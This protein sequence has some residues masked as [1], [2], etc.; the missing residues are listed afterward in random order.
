MS[1]GAEINGKLAI[2]ASRLISGRGRGGELEHQHLAELKSAVGGCRRKGNL[3]EPQQVKRW[4]RKLHQQGEA[5][6]GGR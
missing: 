3:A 5:E 1:G 2:S 4:R 6:G